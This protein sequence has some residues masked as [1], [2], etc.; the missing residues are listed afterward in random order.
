MNDNLRILGSKLEK[1]RKDRKMTIEELA[2]ISKVSKAHISRIEN[3]HQLPSRMI[4]QR[5]GEALDLDAATRFNLEKLSGHLAEP[6]ATHAHIPPQGAH[7]SNTEGS[8]KEGG[9]RDVGQ[10]PTGA[11]DTNTPPGPNF[12]I[13]PATNPVL[14]TDAVLITS[15]QNGLTFDFAQ[16][17]GSGAHQQVVARVGLSLDHGARLYK[18]LGDNLKSAAEKVSEK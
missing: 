15:S 14:Y 17:V 4:L 12:N 13:N 7:Q 18:A 1:V 2:A 8:T 6:F 3:G 9:S 10:N 11:I 16:S 5:L